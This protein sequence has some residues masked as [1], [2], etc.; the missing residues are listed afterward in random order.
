[1]DHKVTNH[2]RTPLRKSKS[3]RVTGM[4]E[5]A[6]GPNK[7]IVP[8]KCPCMRNERRK[9][10]HNTKSF[11]PHAKAVV[12]TG[13]TRE[14]QPVRMLFLDEGGSE[15]I[16]SFYDAIVCRL[17]RGGKSSSN[18]KSVFSFFYWIWRKQEEDG[19]SGSWTYI[20]DVM[21]GMEVLD[22]GASVEQEEQGRIRQAGR[23]ELGSAEEP[24]KCQ[25]TGSL[26]RTAGARV[27]KAKQTID[28]EQRQSVRQRVG[29][30]RQLLKPRLFQTSTR[31]TG[32]SSS[33]TSCLRKSLFQNHQEIFHR[34]RFRTVKRSFTAFV[35]ETSRD[36]SQL[37]FQNHQED[38]SPGSVYPA[39][40]SLASSWNISNH[41]WKGC[42]EIA[43]S[44][45]PAPPS[46]ASSWN[47]SS[48]FWK[49]WGE[50]A[51]SG[52]PAPPSLASSWNIS[53]HFWK[54]CEEIVKQDQGTHLRENWQRS[55]SADEI[56]LDSRVDDSRQVLTKC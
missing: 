30:R 36:L 4:D 49:V 15:T 3:N 29:K 27:E 43:G 21:A 20:G 16:F 6:K 54:G 37:V 28:P 23:E 33:P 50:I 9:L 53:S 46:F 48:H 19:D 22:G 5:K 18:R 8:H 55:S 39:P 26:G 11:S 52:Y 1:M 24:K 42:G 10:R 47:I 12:N 7:Q 34:F 44:G 17:F 35:S 31:C 13:R 32:A 25:R 14:V 40:P 38:L 51:G 45:Y 56:F 2:Q 41:F